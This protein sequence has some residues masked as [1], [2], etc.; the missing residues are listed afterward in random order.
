MNRCVSLCLC[1]CL[2]L[3]PTAGRALPRDVRIDRPLRVASWNLEWLVSPATTRGARAACLAGARAALPCDVA[4]DAARSSAD[5]AML[6]RYADRLDADVV[7]LQEVENPAT[8]ARVFRGYDICLTDRR[9]T[10]NV[11]FAIRRGLPHRCGPDLLTLS[12][13]DHA[14]RGAGLVMDPGG[15]RELHLLAVHL[16]SGCP[17]E[18]LDSPF[19]ACRLLARQLPAVGDWIRSQIA[20]GHRFAVLGDFNRSF[21]R[22]ARDTAWEALTAGTGSLLVDAADG[23]RFRSCYPGQ[24][25]TRYIDHVL[26]GVGRGLRLEPGSFFRVPYAPADVRRYRLSDHCPVGILL[27]IST[28]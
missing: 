5:F 1:L 10:Q 9:A 20:A 21:A 28:P 6:A 26:V 24:T 2:A 3:L 14:R 4:L 13:D 25:H 11:G 18:P 12:E 27:Q 7:A 17:R 23:T 8:A 16:K 19:A 15:P 22:D